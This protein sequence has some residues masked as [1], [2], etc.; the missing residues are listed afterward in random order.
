LKAGDDYE[1]LIPLE[2]I[3]N[4]AIL[5]ALEK[6]YFNEYGPD[7]IKLKNS[8][9]D[10]KEKSLCYILVDGEIFGNN[11]FRAMAGYKKSILSSNPNAK[12]LVHKIGSELDFNL[13]Q[14]LGIP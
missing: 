5:M 13:I 14:N 10:E 8:Y 7:I 11:N 12:I 4:V 6:E 2:Q 3:A 9:K 1:K